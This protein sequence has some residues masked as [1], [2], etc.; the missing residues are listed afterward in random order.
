MLN[1]KSYVQFILKSHPEIYRILAVGCRV[2]KA[3]FFKMKY[4]K[5][6]FAEV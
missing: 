2:E 6:R 5:L 3:I 1:L 4:Y